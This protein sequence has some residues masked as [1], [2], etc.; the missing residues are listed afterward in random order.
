MNKE[1]TTKYLSLYDRAGEDAQYRTVM[2]E[3]RAADVRLLRALE[4]MPPDHRNAVMDYL[5]A[6]HEANRRLLELALRYDEKS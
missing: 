2:E 1:F 6:V 5:G 4:E 3:V